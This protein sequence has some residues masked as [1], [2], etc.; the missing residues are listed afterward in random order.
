MIK[1]VKDTHSPS[2]L[3]T[4]NLKDNF[5]LYYVIVFTYTFNKSSI[6]KF[7]PLPNHHLQQTIIIILN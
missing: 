5:M 2:S 7:I 6:Y 4:V 1:E 3:Q